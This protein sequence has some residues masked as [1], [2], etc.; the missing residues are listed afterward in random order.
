MMIKCRKKPGFQ[1]RLAKSFQKE[2]NE[3]ESDNKT[4]LM[5]HQYLGALKAA[6]ALSNRSFVG[7]ASL[8]EDD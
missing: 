6:A 7:G 1:K 2:L 3:T 4:L 8:G 5:G